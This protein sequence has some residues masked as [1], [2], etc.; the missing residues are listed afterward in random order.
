MHGRTYVAS[1]KYNKLAKQKGSRFT[2]AEINVLVAREES[3]RG[4]KL[5]VGKNGYHGII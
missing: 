1:K 2:D 3:G 4:D 5:G